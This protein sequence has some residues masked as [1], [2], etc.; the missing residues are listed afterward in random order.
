[1][2]HLTLGSERGGVY[3]SVT[4]AMV[5]HHKNLDYQYKSVSLYNKIMS[6]LPLEI[7]SLATLNAIRWVFTENCNANQ[8]VR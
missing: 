6:R 3:T 4:V 1:M 8:L 2:V 7:E 5:I